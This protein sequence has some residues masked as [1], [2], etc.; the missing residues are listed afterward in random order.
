MVISRPDE[1]FCREVYNAVQ[2]ERYEKVF[3][4]ITYSRIIIPAIT[5]WFLTL[6]QNRFN[7]I[8]YN[9]DKPE[10]S[11]SPAPANFINYYL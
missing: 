7:R 11:L 8:V 10:A 2:L 3:N 6:I 4:P 9:F 1:G 5:W